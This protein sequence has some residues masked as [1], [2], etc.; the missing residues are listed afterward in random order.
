MH[1]RTS[2]TGKIEVA[3]NYHNYHYYVGATKISALI[4]STMIRGKY[5]LE[6]IRSHHSLKLAHIQSRIDIYKYSF[7][8]RTITAWN[9]LDIQDIDKI[10]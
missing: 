9:N 6:S 4:T 2:H 1:Y 3:C 8:P 5:L 7:L 10:T